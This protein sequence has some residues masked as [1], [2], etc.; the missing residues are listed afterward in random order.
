[1]AELFLDK[2]QNKTRLFMHERLLANNTQPFQFEKANNGS[3]IT[4]KYKDDSSIQVQRICS[5]S[6][7]TLFNRQSCTLCPPKSFTL[8]INDYQCYSCFTSASAL[9]NYTSTQI[10]RFSYLCERSTSFEQ[11]K[12]NPSM[13]SNKFSLIDYRNKKLGDVESNDKSET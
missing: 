5:Y 12:S 11:V 6:E 9:K 4:W 2:V 8:D 10:S 1:M 7:Y 13:P 3:Q